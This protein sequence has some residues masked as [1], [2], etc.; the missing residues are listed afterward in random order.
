MGVSVTASSN[1]PYTGQPVEPDVTVKL[2]DGTELQRD[3]DYTLSYENNVEEG[4]ATIKITGIGNYTGERTSNFNITKSATTKIS[5]K[6]AGFAISPIADQ[7]FTGSQLKPGIEIKGADGTILTEGQDFTVVS[8]ENNVVVGVAT[9]TAQATNSS[10]YS[11]TLTANFNVVPADL[12]GTSIVMPN[13][14]ANGQALT[15][16][17]VSV[18]F[19]GYALAQGLDYIVA[20]YT[21]NVNVGTAYATLQGIGNFTGTI[22]A[23]FAII[24]SANQTSESD[25]GTTAT[26]PK[27]G[28][29]T[30]AALPIAIA[31]GGAALVAVGTGL[32]LVRRHKRDQQD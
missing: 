29:A 15:P 17:P 16:V 4:L 28:D 21:D 6:D 18:Q 30:N 1:V 11:G 25:A 13:Q 19:N 22:N 14:Y 10:A 8:Y 32:V 5:L 3:V 12:A 23:K 20:S 31:A 9:V 26:L 24:E 27:T 7:V 2:A